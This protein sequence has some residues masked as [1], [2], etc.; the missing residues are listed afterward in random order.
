MYY[1]FSSLLT[2]LWHTELVASVHR[3]HHKKSLHDINQFILQ[4]TYILYT[5]NAAHIQPLHLV[6]L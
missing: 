1:Q 5:L 2:A 6:Q 3:R 4:T